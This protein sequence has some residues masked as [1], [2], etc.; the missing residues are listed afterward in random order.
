[1]SVSPKFQLNI[2]YGGRVIEFFL[3][4]WG[5]NGYRVESSRVVVVVVVGMWIIMLPRTVVHWQSSV[6]V[7]DKFGAEQLFQKLRHN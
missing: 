7:G 5:V 1:M 2:S 4:A 3:L 6:G